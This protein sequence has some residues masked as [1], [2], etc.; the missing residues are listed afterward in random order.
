MADT[1]RTS[2]FAG[3]FNRNSTQDDDKEET[4]ATHPKWSMGI[5]NDPWTT[6]VPGKDTPRHIRVERRF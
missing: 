3:W 5:M 4:R 1:P 2:R 6:E